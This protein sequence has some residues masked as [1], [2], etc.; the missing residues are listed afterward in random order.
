MRNPSLSYARRAF[1]AF[2]FVLLLCGCGGHREGSGGGKAVSPER[3]LAVIAAVN[4]TF[5]A[6]PGGDPVTENAQLAAF[7]TTQPEFEATG[8]SADLCA[9]GRFTDGRVLIVANNR[10]R[11]GVARRAAPSGSRGTGLPEPKSLRLF[12]AMGT[13]F[14]HPAAGFQTALAAHGYDLA[15]G[16]IQ[17]G[18]VEE[19]K[20]LGGDGIFYMDAH[21]GTGTARSNRS[22]FG[23]WTGTQVS[24]SNETD[25]NDDL[26][27]NKL[28]YMSAATDEA[29]DTTSGK[30]IET[31]YAVTPQFV[32]AYMRFGKDSLVIV[33]ACSSDNANFKAACLNAGAGAYAGWTQPVEDGNAFAAATFIF[34]RMLGTNGLFPEYDPAKPPFDLAELRAAMAA[35]TSNTG[36]HY[37]TSPGFGNVPA[38]KFIITAGGG[39]LGVIVP[40]VHEAT[41]DLTKDEMTLT[42][43]FGPDQGTVDVDGTL[44]SVGTPVQI[45]SWTATK[46]VTSTVPDALKVIVRANGRTGNAFPLHAVRIDPAEVT[47]G[48]DASTTF[49]AI[50]TGGGSIVYEWATTGD[51]GHLEDAHGH[52]GKAFTSTDS[53]VTYKSD[54]NAPPDSADDVTVK[55][56]IVNGNEQTLIGSATGYVLIGGG[57]YLLSG[58]GGG[59]ITVDDNLTVWLN[60]TIIFNDARGAF[61]GPRGPFRF[62]AK[63]GDTIRIQVQD[64]YG[65]YSS[66]SNVNITTPSGATTLLQA[67]FQNPTPQGNHAIL[68]DKTFTLP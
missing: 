20:G 31:H 32:S 42:G 6:M 59:P 67:G 51:H 57:E 43:V 33:N 46:I 28:V 2:L 23:I 29:P 12:D 27:S 68:I 3:R 49:T 25:Y 53:S 40:S 10:R 55:A 11:T 21:G 34:D 54:A 13:Y 30:T 36:S 41:V 50:V 4:A 65:F 45:K 22:I 35:E 60:D 66:V 24:P 17:K 19:M 44:L 52:S 61:A 37:D 14:T 47:I 8:V 1:C 63:P 56:K 64:W 38:A 5:A 7:M 39:D 62:T 58:D 9:W 26:R 48:S 16:A 18:T 15:G